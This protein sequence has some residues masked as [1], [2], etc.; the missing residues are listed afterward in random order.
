M[1]RQQAIPNLS[2]QQWL[3]QIKENRLLLWL[4]T[5]IIILSFTCL[6]ILY[7]YPNFIPPDSHSYIEAASQNKTINV[8]PTGYSKFLRL[9][10]CFT[11]SHFILVLLQYL[12]LQSSLLYL[13]FTVQYWLSL[14]KRAFLVIL[15]CSLINPLLP[16]ISNFVSSDCLFT[17]LSLLWLTQLIWIIF[18]PG[19]LLL[20]SH[21]FVL[22]LALMIR[23]NALY[24]PVISLLAI[25]LTQVPPAL[26]RT[27]A[28]AIV[29]LLSTYIGYTQFQYEKLSGKVQYSPFGGWQLAA[30]ALNGYAY[31]EPAPK[32]IPFK[33]R[34]LH[35]ITNR[36]IDS[37]RRLKKRPDAS[38][39]IYYLWNDQS[40]LQQYLRE[41]KH[42][43]DSG[44]SPFKQ[45][46]ALG[47]LYGAYGRFL[48]AKHP[49]PFLRH[50]IWPNLKSYYSPPTGFMGYYNLGRRTVPPVVVSWFGWKNNQL[51]SYFNDKKIQTAEVFPLLLPILHLAFFIGFLILLFA[52][53]FRTSLRY[54]HGLLWWIFLIWGVNMCFSVCS[55]PIELR[56]QLFSMIMTLIFCIVLIERIVSTTGLT[57]KRNSTPILTNAI[58]E[59]VTLTPINIKP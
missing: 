2:F 54:A 1:I 37:L 19:M 8:W 17:A 44:T 55:A 12:L 42:K 34:P 9:A 6:K 7:P 11:N 15:V 47:P 58:S 18:R 30:N 38:I 4:S 36:H 27:G 46:A 13:L 41:N 21:A 33:F 29:L 35:T 31:A 50:F 25:W 23:H 40:P 28:T 14:H 5:T 26:K 10:S 43:Q 22:L 39:G 20:I 3:I 45:W 48:I 24:Y 53:G 51:P 32:R 49:A 56:Y 16:H 52:A 59:P 57:V